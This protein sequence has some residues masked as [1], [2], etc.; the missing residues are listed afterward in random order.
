MCMIAQSDM[1]ASMLDFASI[2]VDPAALPEHTDLRELFEDG[3]RPIELEIGCGKGAFLLRQAQAHP[4]R[5]FLGIE[6]ANK[7]YKFAADRM[8][9]WGL[10]NVRI[11]RTDAR[12]FVMTR[13]AAECLSALHIYHPDPWPKKKHLRRRLIQPPF[14]DAAIRVLRPGAR[15]ALQT[16]HAD[17]FE[18]MKLVT[19]ARH[20]LIAVPFED[21]EHGSVDGSI[22]TNFEIKYLRE[23]R[24]IYRLAFRKSQR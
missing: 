5:N 11:M 19:A 24:P 10:G 2:A 20:D 9:R 21:D 1:I 7:F 16:D 6:W 3:E 18:Q 4:Q 12:E 13:L 17:Y 8:A 15:L 14:L 23:G 22:K